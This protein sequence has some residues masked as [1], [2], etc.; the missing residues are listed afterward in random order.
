MD[1]SANPVGSTFPIAT[2]S[3]AEQAPKVASNGS[4]HLVVWQSG[5]DILGARVSSSGVVIGGVT[6]SNAANSQ[7]VPDIAFNGVYLV[8][9][10]DR[11]DD[12]N[13]IWAARV[14]ADGTVQDSSG[15]LVEA[16]S[17]TGG[18]SGPAVAAA[19]GGKWAIDYD[20]A[21]TAGIA[22]RTFAPK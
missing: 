4:D 7:S 8:A 21:L 12:H 15:V 5:G 14:A 10:R 6:V 9:W 2:I 20:N 16:G 19:P 18:V 11:R 22:Q 1:A 17:E 3:G 13:A